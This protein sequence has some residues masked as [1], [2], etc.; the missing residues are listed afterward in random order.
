MKLKRIR[1]LALAI[2][3]TLPALPLTLPATATATLVTW[4]FQGSD[5]AAMLKSHTAVSGIT[6][7]DIGLNN[8]NQSNRINN[9]Y[10]TTALAVTPTSAQ[11]AYDFSTAFGNASYLSFSITIA[12]GY[13]L[14]LDTF[15][16][17]VASG[18][19][20][21]PDTSVRAFYV[22]SSLTGFGNDENRILVK[23]ANTDGLPVR[24]VDKSLKDVSVTLSDPAFKGID[25]GN[26]IEFRIYIQCDGNT[27][28][29]DFD[30]VTLT[31]SLTA[32]PEPA[33]ATLLPGLLAC[34]CIG[35]LIIRRRW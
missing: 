1:N 5:A 3:A 10:T 31:G 7:L 9:I 14:T 24:P 2:T 22:L 11:N 33:S 25:S 29:L 20:S 26:T 21:S 17:Q 23:G 27:R 19:G 6:A 15:S 30:N 4:D 18:A 32:I 34:A 16:L 8:I 13:T 12:D 35:F 28:A